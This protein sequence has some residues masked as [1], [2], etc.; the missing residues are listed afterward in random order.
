MERVT[1][2]G[3]AGSIN[4]REWQPQHRAIDVKSSGTVRLFVRTFNY[5]GWTATM[6]GHPAALLTDGQTGAMLI[7]LPAGTH[8]V[9]LDFLDTPARRLGAQITL[10]SLLLVLAA[11]ALGALRGLRPARESPASSAAP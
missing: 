2:D 8:L 11:L 6:D 4:I 9:T 10:L 3:G 1:L 5:P 7:S